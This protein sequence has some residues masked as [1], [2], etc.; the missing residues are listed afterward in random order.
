MQIRC[1]WKQDINSE[2]NSWNFKKVVSIL[3]NKFHTIIN[4]LTQFTSASASMFN[5]FNWADFY[6]KNA[7]IFESVIWR[8]LVS[9][10]AQNIELHHYK[11]PDSYF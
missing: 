1:Y 3:P 6:T 5:A 7:A 4:K 9:N 2:P 8:D 11:K 10:F